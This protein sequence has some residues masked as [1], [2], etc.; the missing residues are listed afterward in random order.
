MNLFVGIFFDV[1]GDWVGFGF[2][3][4][5]FLVNIILFVVSFSDDSFFLMIIIFLVR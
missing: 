1:G 3:D 4:L 5:S 2:M